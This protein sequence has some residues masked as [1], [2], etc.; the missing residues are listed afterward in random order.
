MQYQTTALR[1]NSI[2]K[3]MQ[4]YHDLYESVLQNDQAFWL[5]E[6]QTRLS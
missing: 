1:P 6:T 3:S 4:D 5:K 2:L